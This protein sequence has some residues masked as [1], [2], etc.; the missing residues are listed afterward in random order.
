MKE[1]IIEAD[2]LMPLVE[3]DNIEKTLL[4][5]GRSYPENVIK[6]YEKLFNWMKKGEEIKK[7]LFKLEYINTSST[8][9]IIDIIQYYPDTEIIWYYKEND[10]MDETVELFHN[11]TG[12]NFK[13]VI[14]DED[15]VFHITQ[16][17]LDERDRIR[18]FNLI[19]EIGRL[20]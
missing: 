3:Y 17:E 8:K 16:A 18:F 12:R 9:V 4:I 19:K 13:S 14:V 6:E 1:T 11:I 15:E 5:K 20:L 10:D 7:I 2:I